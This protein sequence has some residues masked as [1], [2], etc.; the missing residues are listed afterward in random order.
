MD[1]TRL[2]H[3][4]VEPCKVISTAPNDADSLGRVLYALQGID[5]NK[6]LSNMR[7]PG[8]GGGINANSDNENKK[9]DEFAGGRR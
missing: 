9:N 2:E 8:G 3:W 4:R 7:G 5:L 1:P 6:N